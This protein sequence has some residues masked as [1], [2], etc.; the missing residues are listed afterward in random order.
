M[1]IKKKLIS[2]EKNEKYSNEIKDEME[3]FYEADEMYLGANF[4]RPPEWEISTRSSY[5]VSNE[6][7]L[8]ATTFTSLLEIHELAPQTMENVLNYNHYHTQQE[9]WAIFRSLPL[10]VRYDKLTVEWFKGLQNGTL[11]IPQFMKN[12][13][14]PSLWAYYLTLPTWCRNNPVIYN[15]MHAFE[16]HQPRLD[17][18]KKELA[19]N[20]A[21]S[22]LRPIEGRLRDVIIEV[23]S[24]KKIRLN[25]ELG[26]QM[27]AEQRFYEVDQT[28]LGD[29]SEEETY[30]DDEGIMDLL[31]RGMDDE[32]RAQLD[33]GKLIERLVGGTEYD[34]RM[35]EREIIMSQEQNIDKYQFEAATDEIMVDFMPNG[36]AEVDDVQAADVNK[37]DPI[38]PCNYY[39]NDDGFWN[40]YIQ[41][42]QQRWQDAGMIT[43]RKFFKH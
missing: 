20:L 31:T 28:T 1:G 14:P 8:G 32:E 2:G 4:E 21:C 40:E 38:I 41:H 18:R 17:I 35:K 25:V 42:K 24:S 3:Y 26:K 36:Y 5:T 9:P 11:F 10:L 15:C 16:Y 6:E 19:M 13:N 29:T 39:D 43:H 22:Y 37:H 7:D 34:E 27:M 30:V 12:T 23:A 33:T